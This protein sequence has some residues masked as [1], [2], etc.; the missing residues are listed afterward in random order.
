MYPEY[1]PIDGSEELS[2]E[3]MWTGEQEQIVE[4]VD[5]MTPFAYLNPTENLVVLKLSEQEWTEMLSALYIGAEFTYPDKYL[6]IV[7]NFLK[8][9]HCPPVLEEQECYEYPSYASFMAYSPVNP[10]LEPDTIPEGYETQPFLVNGENGN[11]IPNYEHFDILVPFDA[12]T[13]DVNWFEDIGGQLPQI[14]V[15]VQGAGKAFIK[16]LTQ[17]QGGLAVITVDNPPNLLDILAGIITSA[18]NILDLNLDIVSLP[19]ETASEIIYEVDIVGTGLHTVYIV[20]LPI[21]DDSLI[22]LRFGG[23]FRGVTLCDFVEQP[24]MGIQDIRFNDATCN[25]ETLVDGEWAIVTGWENWLDC[26][27]SGGGGGGGGSLVATTHKQ[28]LGVATVT[29]STASAAAITQ[30]TWAHIFSKSKALIIAHYYVNHSGAA[31][32]S[33]IQLS[34]GSPTVVVEANPSL[35]SG[36][37]KRMLPVVGTWEDIPTGSRNIT[38]LWL[39]SGGTMTLDNSTP[40]VFTIIEYDNASDIYVEDIRILDGELQKKIGGAWIPVTESLNALLDTIAAAAAA[41]QTT[42]NSAVATNTAQQTQINSIITVNNLQNTRLDDLEDWKADAELSIAGLNAQVISLDSRVDALEAAAVNNS[43]WSQTF[44]FLIDD[45]GWVAAGG[46]TYAAG[47]GWQSENGLGT[48]EIRLPSLFAKDGRIT[49]MKLR[50]RADN[51]LGSLPNTY[52]IRFPF[53]GDIGNGYVVSTGTTENFWYKVK[54]IDENYLYV[55]RI[56]MAVGAIDYT[57]REVQFL[58][59]GNNPF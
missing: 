5:C 31:A 27:P 24:L 20:F 14:A 4:G 47:Q 32:V 10:Y 1:D 56:D 3:N 7:A 33:Q 22:P 42:A 58:G 8:G 25:L 55:I 48:L 59:K 9:I 6:Q 23:G 19:P 44:N 12:L 39:T 49:H 57:L 11:D 35:W 16:M 21:L 28:D 38:S 52:E 34:L 53:D 50:L 54:N 45:G 51:A 36:T 13:L 15:G 29:S 18:D 2:Y 40:P 26:V 43:Y 17:V 30:A 37:N 46:E 41:A